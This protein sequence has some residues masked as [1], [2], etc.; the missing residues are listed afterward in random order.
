M[1][2]KTIESALFKTERVKPDSYEALKW[3][4]TQARR[5]A[6]EYIKANGQ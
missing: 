4:D 6:E 1:I 2:A 5:L 3:T